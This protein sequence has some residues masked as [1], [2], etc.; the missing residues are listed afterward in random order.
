[1]FT[2]NEIITRHYPQINAHPWLCKPVT[3]VV[4]HLLHEK[5]IHEFD[6]TYPNFNGIDFVENVLAFFDVSYSVRDSEKERIPAQGKLVIIA[7][8]PIGSLDALAVIK[9]VSEVRQDL[10][11]VANQMLMEFKAL[12]DILLPVN[13]MQGGTP[14]QHLQNIHQHLS[15]E[16]AVLIFPAGEVSRLRPQGVRD[17]RWRSGF[18]RIAKHAKAPILPIYIQAKNS[19]V[20]YGASMIYKPLATALLVK[21]MFKQRT[22]HLPIRVGEEI[23]FNAYCDDDEPME[24]QVKKFK[25]HLYKIARGKKGTFTTQ[26][27]IALPEDR[28]ELAKAIYQCELLGETADNKQIYLYLHDRCSPVMREI[29][30]LREVAFRAVGEGSF[31][32]RDIDI[33]DNHYYHL[34]LWDAKDLEIAGAYRLGDAARLHQPDHPTGLYST[35][36]FTY[37]GCDDTVFKYGLELGRSFVQPKYWGKRALDYLWYGIG[38]FITQYPR[39]QYLFGGVSISDA[40][41]KAAKDLI[42]AFYRTYFPPQMGEAE[43][44][45]PYEV[46]TTAMQAFTGDDYK[47]EF[48]HLKS[49]LVE[50]GLNVPTL[51][52][53][54]TETY[55]KDGVAFLA[56]N[57]DPDFCDCIDGLVV[58]DLSK[59]LEKKRKRYLPANVN[60]K[61]A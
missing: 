51:Y 12:H 10:K 48:T 57:V 20:F 21:E 4:R 35:S 16:G 56:F 26:P 1:M 14:K 47:A 30:R 52:K 49:L 40:Y 39:Y 31:K 3:A 28:R 32:K 17:T 36:L 9:M 61:L 59:L 24:L 33:Y 25:H 27:P 22:K 18:L 38:A 11:V 8:H 19:A 54:Y 41:P 2:A 15:N 29:G 53:Q 37:R 60:V 55:E 43:A 45:M 58:A 34:V 6:R 7:N 13:N 5:D 44:K 50:M 23:P 42:V 46:A